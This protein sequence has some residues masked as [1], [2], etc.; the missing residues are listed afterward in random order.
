M[1]PPSANIPLVLVGS[2]VAF[3]ATFPLAAACHKR[4]PR[5]FWIV[6]RLV[7]A[8]LFLVALWTLSRLA[9][10]APG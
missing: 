7:L 8:G 2:A 6:A 4:A 9:S 10:P 5:A 3:A 1:S